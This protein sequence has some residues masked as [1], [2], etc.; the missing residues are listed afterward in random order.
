MHR[1]TLVDS[2]QL[3]IIRSPM[4][5]TLGKCGGI[6]CYVACIHGIY[7]RYYLGHMTYHTH[8]NV[9]TELQVAKITCAKLYPIFQREIRGSDKCNTS[10]S[11]RCQ[12]IPQI[13]MGSEN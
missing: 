6:S 2:A 1:M 13:S 5:P 9:S 4:S 8:E 7:P 10:P 12:P 11:V 3:R